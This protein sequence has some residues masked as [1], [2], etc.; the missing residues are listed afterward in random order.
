MHQ[1][2]VLLDI[3]LPNDEADNIDHAD[4]PHDTVAQDEEVVE[5]VGGANFSLQQDR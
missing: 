1:L 5:P 2:E 4:K 3:A